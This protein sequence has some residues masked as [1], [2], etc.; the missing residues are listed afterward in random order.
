VVELGEIGGYVEQL[1]ETI[2]APTGTQTCHVDWRASYA[3]DIP[4]L[5]VYAEDLKREVLQQLKG[6]N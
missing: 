4:M 3:W 6:R 1:K 2:A 5:E